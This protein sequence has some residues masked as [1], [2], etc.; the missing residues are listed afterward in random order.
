MS[1]PEPADGPCGS[2]YCWHAH[3][4]RHCPPDPWPDVPDTLPARDL[5]LPTDPPF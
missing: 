1:D 3:N 5:D 4:G 2:G